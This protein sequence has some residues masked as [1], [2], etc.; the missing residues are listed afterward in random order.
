MRSLSFNTFMA[1]N[2]K[3]LGHVKKLK[4]EFTGARVNKGARNLEIPTTYKIHCSKKVIEWIRNVSREFLPPVHYMDSHFV[5]KCFQKKFSSYS[6]SDSQLST[7]KALPYKNLIGQALCS[8][9]YCVSWKSCS[10]VDLFIKVLVY[11][12]FYK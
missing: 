4:C 7:L 1:H 3:T 5:Q 2:K 10:K 9:P 6:V 11:N 8:Y 12:Y